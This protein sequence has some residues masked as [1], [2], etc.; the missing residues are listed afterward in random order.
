M[1][2]REPLEQIRVSLQRGNLVDIS[3]GDTRLPGEKQADLYFLNVPSTGRSEITATPDQVMGIRNKVQVIVGWLMQQGQLGTDHPDYEYRIANEIN[4]PEE[5]QHMYWHEQDPFSATAYSVPG[6]G[7]YL[8]AV[9]KI[10][11]E[12]GADIDFSFTHTG[13]FELEVSLV[14]EAREDEP[15]PSDELP[16]YMKKVVVEEYVEDA[17]RKIEEYKERLKREGRKL[18]VVQDYYYSGERPLEEMSDEEYAL[19]EQVLNEFMELN[20]IQ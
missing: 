9:A 12:K 17:K 20:R 3:R 2:E 16:E 5:L 7:P 14:G 11:K 13:D 19:I 1:K 15:T 10:D 8:L 18:E 4:T 6:E